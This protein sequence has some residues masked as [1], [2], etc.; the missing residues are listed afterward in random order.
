M[1]PGMTWLAEVEDLAIRFPG[2][3]GGAR[4]VLDGVWWRVAV[5]ESVG[6]VGES[7]SGKSLSALALL[8][9]VPPPGEVAGGRVRV[10]GQDVSA[11]TERNLLRVR[12]GVVGLV[13]QEPLAALNP[14]RSI[15]FQVSEAAV[16]HRRVAGRRAARQRAAELLAE[17]GLTPA[18]EFLGAYPH[19]LSGGQR[20]RVLVAAALAGDPELLVA[21]EPAAALDPPA[22]IRLLEL[23]GELQQRRGLALLMISH[24][25]ALVGRTAEMLGVVLCGETVEWGRASDVIA[26]PRHPYARLLLQAVPRLEGCAVDQEPS[27]GGRVPAAAGG[28]QEVWAVSGRCRFAERCPEVM[29]RCRQERPALAVVAP[30]WRVRCFLVHDQAHGGRH[31]ARLD[32]P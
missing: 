10:E 24:D 16:L 6:L 14:V 21:D 5:G 32:N 25:L 18:G 19:Q 4:P 31:P 7:G 22:Q 28:G 12:G 26:A 1:M 30:G 17:V 15:G 11:M 29:P 13:P 20:Q 9:L 23:L 8:G 2:R 3:D 27:Q